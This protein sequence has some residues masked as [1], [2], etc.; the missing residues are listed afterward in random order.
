STNNIVKMWNEWGIAM[1]YHGHY[2]F[3][4]HAYPGRT[5][6]F[7][8]YSGENQKYVLTEQAL[9]AGVEIMNRVMVFDLITNKEGRVIGALGLSLRELKVIVYECKAVMLGTGGVTR[10]WPAPTPTCEF[11][12][13]HPGTS[14]GDGRMMAFRAGA[15]LSNLELVG[16]HAGPKYYARAGQ[17]TWVGVLRERNGQPVGPFIDKPERIYGDITT[18]VHKGIFDE[19]LKSGRGPIYMDMSG[20]SDDDMEYMMYWLRHEGNLGLMNHV[21]EEG[22]SWKNLAVE[23]QTFEMAVA[24]GLIFNFKGETS[25]KGL[26]GGG[27]DG[28][29]G[30]SAAATFGWAAGDASAKYVKTVKAEDTKSGKTDIEARVALFDQLMSRQGGPEWATWQEVGSILQQVMYD[31]CGLLRSAVTMEA[32]MDV[33]KRVKDKAYKLMAAANPH[34]LGRCLEVLNLIDLAELVLVGAY[35]RK[36]TRGQHKRSDYT[37]TNPLNNDKRHNVKLVNGKIITEWEQIK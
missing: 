30:I 32:G 34:E 3:A 7:L 17:A 2:E 5:L 13:A 11:N 33:L 9:K 37:L 19:Y 16:R 6:P 31:Y 24:S 10:L 26:Y 20:I 35:D 23:F 8:K 14:T 27:D 36:E 29:G 21:A 12:R 25:L 22:Q 1:K 28:I 4:G 15:P 18:E